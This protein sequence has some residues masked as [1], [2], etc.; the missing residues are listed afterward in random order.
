MES[1]RER[2]GAY[3]AKTGE[4]KKSLADQLDMSRGTLSQKMSGRTEFTLAEAKTLARI[5]GCTVD[6]L[7]VSPLASQ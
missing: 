2:I 4:S 3:L 6:E 7:F 1:I 5:L